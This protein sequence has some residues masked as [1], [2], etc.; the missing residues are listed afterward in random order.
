MILLYG[1][2]GLEDELLAELAKIK[3]V[4]LRHSPLK[5][6]LQAEDPLFPDRAT[7]KPSLLRS[8]LNPYTR[9]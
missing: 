2:V 7:A 5:R 6:N 9:E 1:S 4:Y 3:N 8:S